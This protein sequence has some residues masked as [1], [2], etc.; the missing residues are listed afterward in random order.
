MPKF[1]FDVKEITKHL[2]FDRLNDMQTQS[3]DVSKDDGDIMLLSKTGSG[4]TVAFLFA[5]LNQL[6]NVERETQAL[7]IV[8]SRELAQQI[9]QVFRSM[10]TGLKLTACYGGHKREIE[11][12]NLIDAPSIIV[13]TAGRLCDHIRRGNIQLDT[14]HT[15]VLDEFDKSLE[16][17]FAEEMEF[18]VGSLKNIKKRVLCSATTIA[19]LPPF[20]KLHEPFEINF[21]DEYIT[22]SLGTDYQKVISPEKDKVETLYNLLCHIGARSSIIFCN[23]RESV[24]RVS[25]FLKEKHVQ[26]VHYHGAMEQRDRD[27]NLFKF[28][29]GSVPFLVCTDLAARG[30]DIAH[31]RNIIH[32]HLPFTEDTFTHRNGRTARMDASGSV[33]LIVGQEEKLPDFA[34]EEIE[35]ITFAEQLHHPEK[36]EWTTVFIH[37]GK[38]NKINKVDIVGFFGNRGDLRK[39]DIGLIE[40]KDF[41][42]FVAI[43]R[44]KV[45]HVM[46]LI[47]DQR[48]KNKKIKIQIA[49]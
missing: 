33:I 21:L 39:E 2:G 13:G 48:L 42:S 18:I 44:S 9:E 34:P 12:N 40:V 5:I 10:R 31:V 23:H 8:P 20:I 27:T 22:E 36:T 29:N 19:Q 16:L 45:G 24:E 7:I 25:E 43:R 46:H 11:E 47:K 4:K 26:C 38:K 35:E 41:F 6:Q 17:G 1:K 28:K 3:L 37:A 30:L 49:K 32:Y 14:I 15:L